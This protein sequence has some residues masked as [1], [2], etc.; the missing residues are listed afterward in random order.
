MKHASSVSSLRARALDDAFP[1]G[2]RVHV[3]RSVARRDDGAGAERIRRRHVRLV[4]NEDELT[5][6]G[7]RGTVEHDVEGAV[8]EVTTT[9]V[10]PSGTV[11]VAPA[12]DDAAPYDETKLPRT[13]AD[14]VTVRSPAT[15][16]SPELAVTLN[17]LVSMVRSP[18]E[19]TTSL[20]ALT[21]NAP[22]TAR[23]PRRRRRPKTR[24][25]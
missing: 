22:A 25:P 17:L 6:G 24:P 19:E 15:S 13:A 8:A 16:V 18:A 1:G 4:A 7:R 14:P 5:G 9:T 12:S 23:S 11:T 2:A 21:V 3:Q 10:F 20:S